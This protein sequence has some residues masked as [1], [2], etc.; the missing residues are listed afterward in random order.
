MSRT[1][2]SIA[3]T[4]SLQ[5]EAAI[6]MHGSPIALVAAGMVSTR[7]RAVKS[8]VS[9]MKRATKKRPVADKTA[10]GLFLFRVISA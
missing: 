4:L 10:A 7:R 1:N 6:A 2:R 5:H 3:T 9:S 8:S